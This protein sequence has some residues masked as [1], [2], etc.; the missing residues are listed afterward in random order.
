MPS[1]TEGLTEGDDPWENPDDAFAASLAAKLLGE[2]PPADQ[3]QSAPEGRSTPDRDPASGQFIA[4]PPVGHPPV[5]EEGT[6]A[7]GAGEEASP[8]QE[9]S[10][11]YQERYEHL[12]VAFDR[13][14]NELGELRTRVEAQEAQ[15]QEPQTPSVSFIP[16][17]LAEQLV[18]QVGPLNAVGEAMELGLDPQ[19]QAFRSIFDAAAEAVE[20]E[21]DRVRLAAQLVA[22]EQAV[23]YEAYIQEHPEAA[24]QTAPEATP[25]SQ[26]AEQ[27]A[28]EAVIKSAVEQLR[29]THPDL[30]GLIPFMEK[31]AERNPAFYDSEIKSG[32]QQ[33]A[34]VALS[35]LA[36]AAVGYRA[37]AQAAGATEGQRTA[38]EVAAARIAAQVTSGAPRPTAAGGT[39]AQNSEEAALQAFYKG[40]REAQVPSVATGLTFGTDAG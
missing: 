36:D 40:F 20:S 3:G 2:D 32:D 37:L 10:D 34:L 22:Y 23:E 16:P 26:W 24:Q 1:V 9:V 6:P 39:P 5:E 27:Q 4:G 18:E 15:R 14:S 25:G 28:Q 35:M 12:R 31:A 30:E 11:P 33:R 19:S 13:Q 8:A 7:E 38:D 17:E 29:T 21:G